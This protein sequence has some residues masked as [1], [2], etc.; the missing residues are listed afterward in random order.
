MI[1]VTPDQKTTLVLRH[2]DWEI[3]G[4]VSARVAISRLMEDKFMA[5]DADAR[6]LPFEHWSNDEATYFPDTPCISSRDFVWPIPSIAIAT[7]T[8]SIPEIEH[9]PPNKKLLIKLLGPVCQLCDKE[10]PYLD[11]TFEHIK[12]RYLGGEHVWDNVT[13]TCARCNGRKG[14]KFPYKRGDG[15][16]LTAPKQPRYI[17]RMTEPQHWKPEWIPHIE[18]NQFGKI[19]WKNFR[20][21]QAALSKGLTI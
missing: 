2:K 19:V 21:Y 14:N 18:R 1:K 16:S 12:P 6:I 3:V 8:F 5:L 11:L 10:F 9:R 17:P 7:S 20:K 13:L 4:V 15:R